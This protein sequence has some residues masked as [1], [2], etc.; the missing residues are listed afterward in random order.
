MGRDY[1]EALKYVNDSKGIW[2]AEVC[3][4][5]KEDGHYNE[6]DSNVLPYAYADIKTLLK[7]IKDG[8]FEFEEYDNCITELRLI[9]KDKVYLYQLSNSIKDTPEEW[10]SYTH[11]PY[12]ALE[13]TLTHNR[14]ALKTYMEFMKESCLGV[15]WL[16]FLS[17]NINKFED[18]KVLDIDQFMNLKDINN[19][20]MHTFYR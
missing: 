19:E 15:D 2:L 20:V 8:L 3:F 5:R 6:I 18:T 11:V 10:F 16:D 7:H 1:F 13:Y 12:P 17:D 9:S 4:I 14:N